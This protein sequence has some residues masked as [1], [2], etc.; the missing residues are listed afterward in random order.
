[1][2]DSL[3]VSEKVRSVAQMARPEL[4][5]E[6]QAQFGTPPPPK[7]RVELMRPVL[8]YRIQENAWGLSAP[9]RQT[10]IQELASDANRRRFKTGTKI[11]REWKGKLHEVAVTAEGYIYDGEVYKSLSPIATRITGT[12]WSGPAFFGTKPKESSR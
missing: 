4:V 10:R 6:W 12:R 1:M 9:K 5:S 3:R 2:T 8:I 11:I 7:L